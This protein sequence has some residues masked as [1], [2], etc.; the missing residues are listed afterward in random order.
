MKNVH[1][2]LF[3]FFKPHASIL[4]INKTK[5]ALNRSEQLHSANHIKQNDQMLCSIQVN[6]VFHHRL[7]HQQDQR[8]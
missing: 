8:S 1:E 5:Y 4:L 7:K 2:Y 3:Y 6:Y